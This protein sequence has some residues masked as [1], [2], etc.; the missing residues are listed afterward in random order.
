MSGNWP[1]HPEISV[2]MAVRDGDAFLPE[3]LASLQAQTERNFEMI[4]VDDGSRD[5]T[6]QILHAAAAHDARIRVLRNDAG[7]GVTESLNRGLAACRAPLVARADAD[8]LHHPERLAAELAFMRATPDVDVV[9]C[10]FGRINA[11]GQP[12]A[13]T[14]SLVTGSETIRFEM[15]LSNCLLHPGVMFRA[16]AVRAAGGYD[17]AFPNA[18]DSELW[19]R[20]RMTSR[21]ENLPPELVRYRVHPRSVTRRRGSEGERIS[22]KVPARELSAY[23]GVNFTP[24]SVRPMV[25]L[26]QGHEA[27]VFEDIIAG[28]RDLRSL[29]QVARR[30]ESP[31]IVSY[32]RQR[33]A[34]AL[35]RQAEFSG[36][37]S[38]ARARQYTAASLSWQMR[39]FVL[40]RLASMYL[41]KRRTTA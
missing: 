36:S 25:R 6:P 13:K 12:L 30:R 27:L 18:Q 39:R 19:A 8:D 32:L 29:L 35:L 4:V 9:S 41:G 21:M 11:S 2:L 23:L 40:V 14:T 16:D 7:I 31:A 17:T 22:L 20:M 33:T 3:T 10:A 15:L 24:E 28:E 38:L 5:G 26:Y 34:N 1:E 37:T